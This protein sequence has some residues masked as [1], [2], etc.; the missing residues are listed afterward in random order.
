VLLL[1]ISFQIVSRDL[2]HFLLGH[3]ISSPHAWPAGFKPAGP[4]FLWLVLNQRVL[5]SLV[6]FKPA[7]PFF[8]GWF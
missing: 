8:F 3:D 5:F 7:G 6:S 2:E 1:I 4:F